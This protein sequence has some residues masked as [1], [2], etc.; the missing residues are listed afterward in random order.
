MDFEFN[1][2][3]PIYMQI[4]E[5]IKLQIISG[6]LEPLSRL[7]S[8]RELAVSVKVNPNTVQKALSE[9]ETTGLIFTERTNGKFVTDNISLI[10]KFKEEYAA[11]LCRDFLFN[12]QKAGFTESDAINYIKELGGK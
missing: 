10:E 9:L 11:T 7:P 12:I 6:E 3:T 1:N 5:N 2:T 4:V 8:V